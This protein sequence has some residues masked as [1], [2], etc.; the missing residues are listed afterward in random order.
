MKR[1]LQK[2]P[3]LQ[4]RRKQQKY[5]VVDPSNIKSNI[6][7]TI[8]NLQQNSECR[9]FSFRLG[10][11]VIFTP[12]W[13]VFLESSMEGINKR[14]YHVKKTFYIWNR[15]TESCFRDVIV[16]FK[17]NP[18]FK[19]QYGSDYINQFFHYHLFEDMFIYCLP[20][21]NTLEDSNLKIK[22]Y[23][24]SNS[25]DFEYQIFRLNLTNKNCKP[26][27]LFSTIGRHFL[28]DNFWFCKNILFNGRLIYQIFPEKTF[29]LNDMS[30]HTISR[31][32]P[33][34]VHIDDNQIIVVFHCSGYD[35][36][37]DY[38]TKILRFDIKSGEL[39]KNIIN[40]SEYTKIHYWN[41]YLY[42]RQF[43][44]YEKCAHL[45]KYNLKNNVETHFEI[46]NLFY[47]R[48]YEK[49]E[50][51]KFKDLPFVPYKLMTDNWDSS[52]YFL[53]NYVN[54]TMTKFSTGLYLYNILSCGKLVF[55]KDEIDFEKYH[56][57]IEYSNN[58][59]IFY[60]YD[61]YPINFIW[62]EKSIIDSNLISDKQINKKHKSGLQND[63]LE[64][65]FEKMEM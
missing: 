35:E 54:N 15:E 47:E 27:Y 33:N 16:E 13:F 51:F 40:T 5:P 31:T 64:D 28:F 24:N 29:L 22:K 21:N 38:K 36:K 62:F 55:V 14:V 11:P 20:V 7:K 46:P 25:K 65:L 26:K 49:Y 9:I 58:I 3:E 41:N 4:K 59:N 32:S 45:I 57:N 37:T 18:F 61:Y 43:T 19:T 60:I 1:V 48:K 42:L 23:T 30:D 50:F 10:E 34:L 63:N 56:D 17:F 12:K 52:E 2:S 44:I 53:Y 6:D 8:S 39:T